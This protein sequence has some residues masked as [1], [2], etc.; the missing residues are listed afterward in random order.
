ML[1]EAYGSLVQ[2]ALAGIV[3]WKSALSLGF[4]V[5]IGFPVSMLVGASL[6][7]NKSWML[8]VIHAGDWF[9]KML[10]M[11]VIVAVWPRRRAIPLA[12]RP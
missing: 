5:W 3:D 2:S 4:W 12:R 7:D 6:W 1:S 11:S 10:L 9:V 8:T